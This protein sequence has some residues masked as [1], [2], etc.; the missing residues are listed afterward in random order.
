MLRVCSTQIR[1]Q[2]ALNEK[3]EFIKVETIVNVVIL[4]W[5]G[6]SSLQV[7]V[8][9]IM[10]AMLWI[11]WNIITSRVNV[12]SPKRRISLCCIAIGFM[13]NAIPVSSSSPYWVQVKGDKGNP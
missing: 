3:A 5:A 9:P 7:P 6:R 11:C 12:R 10:A 1:H 2:V 4:P 13:S 8:A